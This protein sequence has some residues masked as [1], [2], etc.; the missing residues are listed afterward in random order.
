MYQV[1]SEVGMGWTS[2]CRPVT[3]L[4]NRCLRGK[5]FACNIFII[6]C[7]VITQCT[8]SSLRKNK[9]RWARMCGNSITATQMSGSLQYTKSFKKY[10]IRLRQNWFYRCTRDPIYIG[11]H[12][13]QR[14]MRTESE[15][16]TKTSLNRWHNKKLQH[17]AWHVHVWEDYMLIALSTCA[18]QVLHWGEP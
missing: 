4:C 16:A 2:G 15:R 7:T 17:L 10:I 5:N 11:V 3:P 13:Q 1:S 8:G 9:S 6:S 14:C 12:K 18:N